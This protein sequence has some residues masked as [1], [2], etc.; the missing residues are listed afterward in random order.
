MALNVTRSVQTPDMNGN[1]SRHQRTGS[2]DGSEKDAG[3]GVQFNDLDGSEVTAG[4]QKGESRGRD[5][6]EA[7][8]LD[9]RLQGVHPAPPPQLLLFFIWEFSSDFAVMETVKLDTLSNISF[10]SSSDFS[11]VAAI[12]IPFVSHSPLQLASGDTV[13]SKRDARQI[14]MIR[15]SATV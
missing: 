1:I 6:E 11:R 5:T 8:A 14:R 15:Y 13:V 12:C 7:L 4:F 9:A 2:H 10:D 3:E